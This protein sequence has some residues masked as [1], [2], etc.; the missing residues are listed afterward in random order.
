MEGD[1]LPRYEKP[2]VA[3]NIW[4]WLY[5][6]WVEVVDLPFVE[7]SGRKREY[8]TPAGKKEE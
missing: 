1:S 2:H 6:K 5:L 3:M 8:K 4:G 7:L